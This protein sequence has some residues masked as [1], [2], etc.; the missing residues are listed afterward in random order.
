MPLPFASPDPPAVRTSDSHMSEEAVSAS[1]SIQLIEVPGRWLDRLLGAFGDLPVEQ[2][3]EAA[4]YALLEAVLASVP[5]HG[6]GA[7]ILVDGR[8]VAVRVGAVGKQSAS[9]E[10]ERLF[11]GFAHER[12]LSLPDADCISLH[13]AADDLVVESDVYPPLQLLHRAGFLL[14]AARAHARAHSQGLTLQ[15][16]VEERVS[17]VI[18]SEKLASLGQ[19]AAGIAHELNNPL[20]SI[21]AYT[22]FLTRRA[23]ER[24]DE[25]DIERLRRIAESAQRVLQLSRDLVAYARPAETAHPVVVSSIVDQAIVFCE[26]ELAEYHVAV[27]RIFGDGVL[28]VRGLSTQLAQVFVNLIV[29]ACHSMPESGGSIAV[30]TELVPGDTHVRVSFADTGRGIAAA[31]LG[32]IFEPFFTTKGEGKGS[33][34]G[35]AIVRDILDAHAGTISVRSSEGEGTTFELLLPVATPSR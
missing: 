28:P 4:T 31:H 32:R 35:L 12:A 3:E 19:M 16:A 20:T 21:V 13:L 22:D 5:G 17:Q 15:R 6:I 23:S 9:P 24:N 34:L 10:G 30:S 8:E 7:R 29:N 1:R 33:G 27:E 11:P 14:R 18:Q 26:H 25:A 2:G